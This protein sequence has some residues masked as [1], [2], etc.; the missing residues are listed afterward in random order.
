MSVEV[1]SVVEKV[2]KPN[3]GKQS[4]YL[5]IPDSIFEQFYGGAAGGGKSEVLMMKPIVKGWVENNR[6]QGIVLRRT[7]KELEES[8]IE[9]SKRGGISKDGIEIPSFSDFGAVYNEQKKKW[10][11]PSG[12]TITFGH[13]E[14]EADIRKYDTAEYQYVAFD[15]LTSFTEFQYKFMAFSRCRSSIPGIP[16]IV[17]SASNPGNIGH[18]WV[19]ERFVE[20]C[21]EGGKILA[22]KIRV[23]GVW[24]CQS[25]NCNFSSTKPLMSCPLCEGRIDEYKVIKRIFI[26]AFLADNPKL[27]ENDPLYRVRMEMLPEAERRAKALG[28]W[29]TFTGQVFSEWRAEHF[30]GEPDNALHVKNLGV[31]DVRLPRILSIDW[32]Y[33]AMNHCIFGVP[34][35]KDKAYIYK[36][37]TTENE[38]GEIE[39]RTV[40]VWTTEIANACL[41]EGINP[42]IVLDP[43][44]WQQRGVETIADQFIKT[45]KEVTGR[46][47]KLE[48]ADNDRIGGKLLVHDFLRWKSREKLIREINIQYD[49]E[50]ADW[51]FR[52]KGIEAHKAYLL[53][54]VEQSG[55]IEEEIPRLTISPECK[56]LIRT[57]PL[58]IYDEKKDKNTEDV[59]EFVGDDPYDNIRYFLKKISSKKL[60]QF[61]VDALSKEKEEK[62]VDPNILYRK[63]EMLEAKKK[64]VISISRGYRRRA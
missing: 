35:P 28:D 34:L 47:P 12:A 24:W 56:T 62:E 41:L 6:F 1:Q 58:C 36:E 46:S 23:A 37:M 29:W 44:A 43:S 18:R 9:R 13:A 8:L 27:M 22:E 10:R 42:D 26:K 7:Y 60:D 50:R 17:G 4:L 3:A 52:N 11:F 40:K 51:I 61:I 48:K 21:R 32:G 14:E 15:E 39:P 59:K 16:A 2:W 33:R 20:P 57:I 31:P 19:R 49:P 55:I 64:K 54:F 5:S 38:T 53:Q 25:N 63:M 45:W 30:P